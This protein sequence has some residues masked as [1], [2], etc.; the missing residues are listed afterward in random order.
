MIFRGIFLRWSRKPSV[1][2]PSPIEVK[3]LMLKRVLRGLLRGKSPMKHSCMNGSSRRVRIFFSP[4][5]S[6]NSWKRILMKIRDEDVVSS[7]LSW[8]YSKH[9][10]GSASVC[11]K[12]A[13]NFATF[14]NLFVSYLWIDWY[15]T[16]NCWSKAS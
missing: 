13:K 14:L 1:S 9:V 16:T 8:T 10:Q 11:N 7:S 5:N 6:A 15:C 4:M 12:W 2:P 3:K